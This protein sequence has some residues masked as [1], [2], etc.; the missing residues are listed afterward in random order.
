M[1]CRQPGCTGTIV[2]GYCDVCGMPLSAPAGR[3]SGGSTGSDKPRRFAAGPEPGQIRP[4][5]GQIRTQPPSS[6]QA[7]QRASGPLGRRGGPCPQPGCRGTIVDGYCNVCGNPPDAKPPSATPE[8]LGTTLSTTATAAELGTVLM[9][10][11]LAGPGAERTSVRSDAHRSRTRIGA[12]VTT[13]PPAPAIDPAKAVLSDPVVPEPRRTCPKCGKSVGRGHD[14]KPGDPE[15]TCP[16]CGAAFSFYPAIKPGELVAQQYEV[17]GAIAYGGM[18]WIYLA[19][20]RNVSDRWVVLKGLLNAA[21]DD[22]SAAAKS[23]KEFLAAVENPL[24]VE[25]YNFVSHADARY[26]V[27]EYVPGR[28]ITELLKQRMAANKGSHDPLPVDWALAYLIEILPAFTYLHDNGLLYCDF[29]PDNLMQVG[30]S[31]KLIDLG[32]VRRINDQTSPIFGT[33]GYQAPEIADTGPT[34]ASDIYTLGRGLVVMSSEFRGYQT[35]YVDT[36]PP[37]SKMPLFA[38]HDSFY[39]LVKRAC[40]PVPSDRFQ[41]AEDLRVQAMGV[42]REVVARRTPAAA[43]TSAPSTLFTPP[44]TAG[45]GHGWEQ[46]PKLLADPADPMTNWIASITLEDA[47]ERMGALERAPQRSA[48]VMLTQIEIALSLGDHGTASRIIRE[49]LKADP[50]DWRAIWMQGLAAVASHSWHE[51]QA[52]FNTVYAQIPGELA[53]KFALAVTC[54]HSEQPRLAEELFAICASTGAGYVTPSAFAM[55]RIR[56]ARGD[57]DGALDALDLVPVTSRGYSDARTTRATLMLQ[58]DGNLADLDQA[59]QAIQAAKLDQIT[60]TTLQAE[61]LEKVVRLVHAAHGRPVGPFDGQPATER[62]LRPKLERAYRDLAT[63]TRDDDERRRLIT[64]ADSTRRW[65]LL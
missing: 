42:L 57:Q 13:V 25:I 45:E 59:W 55:A 65:S 12:G 46:L 16:N 52:P 36:L 32:A 9:G 34:I 54:E 20:D 64:Q 58:R 14:G 62:N 56:L 29:K 24:I 63:W 19:K 28:S 30:D 41:S 5:P 61:V 17:A 26:I 15:G 7:P 53:P 44:L 31:V 37:L 49:L 43:T 10:S 33:V 21:D 48:Q 22:A 39:R 1:K 18:G 8:L 2:D 50:W 23:E 35:E 51:A 27:M 60:A 4:E 6:H 3:A 47:R 40:A 11:A 38:E